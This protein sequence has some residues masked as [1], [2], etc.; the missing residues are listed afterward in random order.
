MLIPV[1]LNAARRLQPLSA[2]RITVFKTGADRGID[3]HCAAPA[4]GGFKTCRTE[5]QQGCASETRGG[6]RSRSRCPTRRTGGGAPFCVSRELQRGP[7]IGGTWAGFPSPYNRFPVDRP[8]D[9]ESAVWWERPQQLDVRGVVPA[10]LQVTQP[11]ERHR[12]TGAAH[13]SIALHPPL[14]SHR[15]P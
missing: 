5:D 14:G 11:Q 8:T 7:S 4:D 10:G 6:S 1:S 3:R 12:G 13:S 15:P 9:C 2:M